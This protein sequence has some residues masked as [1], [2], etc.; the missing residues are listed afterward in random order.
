MFAPATSPFFGFLGNQPE[1]S[2]WRT[3]LWQLKL[4]LSALNVVVSEF[5]KTVSGTLVMEKFSDTIARI[6]TT[7]FRA[8]IQCLTQNFP[9]FCSLVTIEVGSDV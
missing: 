1:F 8:K 3:R 6:V 9:L 2:K 5:G 7:G 4:R